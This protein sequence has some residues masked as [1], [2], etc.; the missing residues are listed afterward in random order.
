MIRP[1][2]R[3]NREKK[4]KMSKRDHAHRLDGRSK[5]THIETSEKKKERHTKRP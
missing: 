3:E 5:S 1:Q 2:Q 4:T